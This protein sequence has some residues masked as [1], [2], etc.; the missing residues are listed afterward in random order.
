MCVMVI[1]GHWVVWEARRGS[2]LSLQV[3]SLAST[4]AESEL[5]KQKDREE[6]AHCQVRHEPRTLNRPHECIH[7]LCVPRV[8]CH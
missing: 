8:S 7:G 1:Q 3:D 4:E 5:H 2:G 6:G